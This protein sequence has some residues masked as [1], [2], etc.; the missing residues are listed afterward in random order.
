MAESIRGLN[1]MIGADTTSLGKALSDVNKQ[2]RSI[3]SELKQVNRGLKFDP[4]STTLLTQKQ[5]LLGKSIETTREKLNRLKSVQDQVNKQFKSGEINEG[6]YRAFQR[7]IDVTQNKLK[8]LEGQLKST[9]PAMQSFGEKA[10][11]ASEKLR[12]AGSTATS[13]GKTMSLGITTPLVGA[14]A[15]AIKIG[16]DFE[17]SMSQAAGALN[18]P[19]SQM[20]SLRDLALKTGQ[21]TQFSATEAGNA[22]TELAK[23]GLTEAQI[24]GG[25]LKATMDLAASS[26]MD[27]G[28]AANTV[29]QAMGAF[30]LSASQSSQA[31]N[32]LAGAAAAS[33]TDVEPLSQGLA[34]C[35]AQAHMAGWSIQDT[36]AVLGEFADAGVVGSDAGTSLKTMLQR[37]G[38]PTSTASKEMDSLGINVWDSS[39]HMKNASGIAQELQSKMAGLSDSQKQ[40][41][42]S[43][44]FGSDATR[45]ASILMNNGASGLQKYT[46]ATNDQSSASRLA[47]SQMGETS[48]AIEQML[49]ALETAGIKLQQ[50]LVPTI[51]AIANKIG[52]LA[53]AFSNLSPTA[54]TIIL[55]VA[56]IAAAIGPLLIVIGGILSVIGTV[57]GAIGVVATGAAAATPAIAGLAAVFSVLTGPVGIAIAVMA[58]V[59]AIVF[60]VINNWTTLKT[61]FAGIGTFIVGI[62]TSLGTTIASIWTSIT[63]TAS[64]IW[65]S[66]GTTI[67]TIATSIVTTISSIWS[68]LVGIVSSVWNRIVTVIT[69]VVSGIVNN[70]T[71]Y[72]N[73]IL[74]GITAIFSGI[75]SFFS[76]VWEVIKNIFLGALLLLIDLVTG[77]FT[78]LGEDAQMIW[79]NIKA[80]FEA[81]WNGIKAIFS[82]AIQII[83]STLSTAWS[84]ITSVVTT[85]WNGIKS[86]LSGVWNG[87]KSLASSAFNA[88]KSAIS[89]IV[90]GT[91]N[92]IRNIWNGILNFFRNLPSNLATLGRNMFNAMKNGITSVLSTLGGVIRNGFSSAINY[93]KS[94]PSQFLQWGKDMI[95]NLINGVKSMIGAV[96]DAISGVGDKIRGLLHHSTPDEGPLQHDDTWGYDMMQNIIDGIEKNSGGVVKAVSGVAE[97]MSSYLHFSAPDKGALSDFAKWMPDFVKGLAQGIKD[98]TVYVRNAAMKLGS[99]IADSVMPERDT[100]AS[101][102][103]AYTKGIMSADK[104]L[105]DLDGSNKI[106][107]IS[108]KDEEENMRNLLGVMTNQSTEINILTSEYNKLGKKF[109]YNSDKAL[110]VL[111]KIQDLRAEYQKTGQDIQD[112]ADKM[113]DAQ[114]DTINDVNDKIKDAL[115]QRYSDEKDAAEKQVK[116]AT[117]TQTKILQAKI[118]ALDDQESSLDSQYADEDDADKE[119]ELRRQLNMHWGAEKKKELQ[120]E[121][122]DLIKTRERRHQ[123][124]QLDQQKQSLQDQIDA[125]KDQQDQT[126]ASLDDFYD[127][128]LSD[129]NLEAESEKTLMNSSQQDLVA[130]LHSYGEDYKLAGQDLGTRL[131]EGFKAPLSTLQGMF[132]NLSKSLSMIQN[133]G[134]IP[135]SASLADVQAYLNQGGTSSSGTQIVNLNATQPTTIITQTYLDSKQ[136]AKTITPYVSKIQGKNLVLD[137]RGL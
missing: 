9:S 123:K 119:A 69:T 65:T 18:K 37:L 30:G 74:P 21:D 92:T 75:Q 28:T 3:Q 136:V 101:Y 97:Q 56:G 7:E 24:K 61:F 90:T 57:A 100:R 10:N 85:V 42:M 12:T 15:A 33:S 14:A 41:A 124:E 32:A 73:M 104:A 43:T 70:V 25:S 112:L 44:I 113:K 29:V 47:A 60:I 108:T 6:Q 137:K 59:A 117:D 39:G 5:E 89:S 2:S 51:T 134:V 96:G 64:T 135:N 88:M 125:L 83:V 27:L 122:D 79:N 76:G 103:S 13:I 110:D 81:I 46:K 77:N 126:L 114:I 55:A 118:D 8:N 45:A 22:I 132:D 11:E 91:I 94:L 95:Q 52:D 109:G 99:I 86:F 38:A 31:V 78:Q 107:E 87:L 35:A 50:A 63:T 71:N 105:I 62:F 93:I 48:K 121:L 116:L 115:K 58:G 120:D 23:G 106:L 130:L 127:Q 98:N 128:K 34:Q 72:F 131:I 1:V 54:Q 111:K 129:A 53:T 20:G 133:V 4:S 40:A 68:G 17:T 84:G 49:G 80:G 102:L 16:N 26:S 67:T 36:T 66:I 82:G 19:V